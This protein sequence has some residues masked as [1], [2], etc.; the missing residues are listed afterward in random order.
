M[1]VCALAIGAHRT[2]KTE[3]LKAKPTRNPSFGRI[4]ISFFLLAWRERIRGL[5][6]YNLPQIIA[7]FSARARFSTRPCF[8][9]LAIP[10]DSQSADP[11]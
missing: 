5:P 2:S 11:L 3:R 10:A 4:F 6:L 7:D 1:S 8:N 9:Y